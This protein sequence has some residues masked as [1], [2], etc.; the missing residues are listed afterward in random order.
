[1]KTLWIA[2]GTYLA[3]CAVDNNA[4]VLQGIFWLCFQGSQV[5]GNFFAA[6]VLTSHTAQMAFFVILL[7]VA[8]GSVFIFASLTPAAKK[9]NMEA[10]TYI[11]EVADEQEPEDK[12]ATPNPET[13]SKPMT[14][15]SVISDVK[16]SL[17]STF[18]VMVSKKMV[19]LL[20]FVAYAGLVVTYFCGVV[21]LLV[22]DK[23]KAD[24]VTNKI[25]INRN[26][27][28]VM[29][30]F[31]IADSIGGFFFGKITNILGKKLG[32]FIIFAVGIFACL[33]TF[34]SQ[35]FVFLLSLKLKIDKWFWSRVVFS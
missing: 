16:Q 22:N 12:H 24:G 34:C 6:L 10:A 9:L 28:V 18:S 20:T 8:I 21:P 11:G 33:V 31:G 1:M 7:V 3:E 14:Y 5:F 17:G 15:E 25:T 19:T 29:I 23:L 26:T 2:Q 27:A 4:D 30:F 32:M 35:Y 13:V